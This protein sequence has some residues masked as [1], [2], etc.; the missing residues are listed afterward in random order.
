MKRLSYGEPGHRTGVSMKLYRVCLL[1]EEYISKMNGIQ[2]EGSGLEQSSAANKDTVEP[3]LAGKKSGDGLLDQLASSS[4]QED[5]GRQSIDHISKG[6]SLSSN[7]RYFKKVVKDFKEDLAERQIPRSLLMLNRVLI[8]LCL[9]V[10]SLASAEYIIK[11]DT[12]TAY[13]EYHERG[14]SA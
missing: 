6:G 14:L 12:V 9:I 3:N 7:V 13:K 5:K 1:S 2:F 4:N 10:V 8:V 11:V